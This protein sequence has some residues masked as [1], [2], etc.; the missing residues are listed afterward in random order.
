M[1]EMLLSQRSR[2]C[3]TFSMTTESHLLRAK[4]TALHQQIFLVLRDG[5]IQGLYAPGTA[6]PKEEA[7]VKL[8]GVARATVR[9]ALADLEAE[10]LVQRRHGSGT[11]VRANLSTGANIASLSFV[12]ELRQN[13]QTTD[14]Q[15]IT[16]E[17]VAPPPWVSAVM[18]IPRED[19]AVRAVRM[20]LLGKTPAMLTEAWV[21]R[22]AAV[23]VTAATLKKHAMYKIVMAHGVEF[24][25]VVQEISAES[26]D[27]YKAGLLHCELSTALIRLT[28]LMHDKG[29]RPV[30][31]VTAHMLPQHSRILMEIPGDAIDTLSAGHIVHDPLLAETAEPRTKRQQAS[32]KH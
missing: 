30:M 9:R 7:L 13:A 6:L 19:L 5:I 23:G 3:Y 21:R 31:H 20:R 27:P 32:K 2:I 24:G 18:Q 26:A 10:G 4:G 11:F 14:V 12:D 15:V 29:G 28:R 8:F 1:P 22:D 16:V 25:R 17:T